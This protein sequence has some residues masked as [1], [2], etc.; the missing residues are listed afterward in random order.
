MIATLALNY[1][2]LLTLSINN[3]QTTSQDANIYLRCTTQQTLEFTRPDGTLST[4]ISPNQSE[5]LLWVSENRLSVIS[6]TVMSDW[7]SNFATICPG[8]LR[9]NA[10]SI[11]YNGEELGCPYDGVYFGPSGIVNISRL[12][13]NIRAEKSRAQSDG[14]MMRTIFN[15]RCERIED[16]MGSRAF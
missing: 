4:R 16:P 10:N 6:P 15:G 2:L 11:Y 7:S 8:A 9:V 1:L 12:N 13:G 5:Y 3:V 14:S